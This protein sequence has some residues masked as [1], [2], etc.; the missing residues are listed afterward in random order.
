MSTEL[1]LANA[2][3]NMADVETKCNDLHGGTQIVF[4]F[5]NDYGAS[6]VCH[7]GSYGSASGLFELAVI[8]FTGDGMDGF[9]LA[10]DTPVTDD[11]LGWLTADDVVHHLGEIQAL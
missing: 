10:Y 9:S 2:V 1:S 5:G 6:V 3:A 7:S 8:R 4:R 11:V